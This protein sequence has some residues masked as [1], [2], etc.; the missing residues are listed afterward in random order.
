VIAAMKGAHNWNEHQASPCAIRA[1][2][3]LVSDGAVPARQGDQIA[4][5]L[6]GHQPGGPA[7]GAEKRPSAVTEVSHM[8]SMV[9]AVQRSTSPNSSGAH[10]LVRHVSN[11]VTQVPSAVVVRSSP[12]SSAEFGRLLA[13]CDLNHIGESLR[14]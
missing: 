14:P 6:T 5:A 8:L 7:N 10:R 4:A 12:L 1:A 9:S 2:G 11:R 3:Q 13:E